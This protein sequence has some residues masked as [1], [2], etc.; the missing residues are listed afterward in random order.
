MDLQSARDLQAELL[1][2]GLP[3]GVAL[4]I[5]P[6]KADYYQLA[7]RIQHETSKTMKILAYIRDRAHEE[8]DVRFIGTV[9]LQ[10]P[11]EPL[12]LGASCGRRDAGIGT[13]GPLVRIDGSEPIYVVSNNHVLANNN[14]GQCGDE[15]LHPGAPNVL[16][17]DHEPPHRIGS[18]AGFVELLPWGQ[19][20]AVDAAWCRLDDGIE[21]TSEIGEVADPEEL[22]LGIR[23]AKRGRATGY[24][25]GRLSAFVMQNFY[26]ECPPLGVLHF[27]DQI[28]ISPD[29]V[30]PFFSMGGDSGSLVYQRGTNRAVG[31]LFAATKPSLEPNDSATYV[32]PMPA[33]L[34]HLGA[35]LAA[36]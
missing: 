15:I 28:E 9:E 12:T 35:T 30:D 14:Q 5:A 13:L 32:N 10:C 17:V 4:G 1:S 16:T 34:E 26:L 36:Q 25:E 19:P 31:L 3:I 7:V 20:N 33:V 23:V 22:E 27:M 11:C 2:E 21:F 18:L 29:G 6:I 8:V 24:T